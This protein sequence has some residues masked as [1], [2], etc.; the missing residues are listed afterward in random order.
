V[1]P[2]ILSH[3]FN[4]RALSKIAH[5]VVKD[6]PILLGEQ[7]Y[8]GDKRSETAWRSR[9]RSYVEFAGEKVPLSAVEK[10]TIQALGRPRPFPCLVL[11]GFKPVSAIPLH[12]TMRTSYFVYPNETDC[13]GSL[14]A[15]VHLHTAMI[16]LQVM[17]IGSFAPPR[18]TKARYVALRALP[19]ELD[20]DEEALV[21]PP[22]MLITY[23]PYEDE[24]RTVP[25]D[26]ATQHL[27]E[28]G[29]NI[30]RE[31]LVSAAIAVVQKQTLAGAEIGGQ[32][33]NA[34]ASRLWNYVERVAL[35]E[36]KKKEKVYDTEIIV[37][38]VL[39]RA[40]VEIEAFAALLPAD[41]VVTK[42]RKAPAAAKS[43]AAA[44]PKVEDTTG[45]DWEEAYRNDTLL[46]FKNDEL[47]VKLKSLGQ[48]VGGTKA[49]LAER[50]SAALT[51]LY[52]DGHDDDGGVDNDD[53]D[54]NP[55]G[56]VKMEHYDADDD[57]ADMD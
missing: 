53:T 39:Q 19:A 54:V 48:A 29:L 16:N 7:R 41:V 38:Q 14:D 5:Y 52:G 11:H 18:S 45:I 37:E 30:A 32:F 56:K 47:K 43:A 3:F 24:N 8:Y 22:G 55:Q 44:K 17:A 26:K 13:A 21:A 51:A 10:A 25:V 2:I 12:H 15:F 6:T 57:D 40:G 35:D 4:A 50:L 1:L 34:Y 31:E 36:G 49:V 9:E 46:Q 27:E 42:K 23:L 20:D 33:E 28:T